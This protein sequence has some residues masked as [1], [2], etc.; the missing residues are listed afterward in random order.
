VDASIRINKPVVQHSRGRRS[1]ITGSPGAG[2]IRIGGFRHEGST[3]QSRLL[4][5]LIRG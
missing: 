3:G 4:V 2:N 1:E 5:A